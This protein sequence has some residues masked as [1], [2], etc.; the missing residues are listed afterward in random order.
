M[1]FA[2]S[3]MQSQLALAPN[4]LVL[5][6][7]CR[8]VFPPAGTIIPRKPPTARIGETC[9]IIRNYQ[10]LRLAFPLSSFIN[11]RKLP[12][13][14]V[15]LAKFASAVFSF[16]PIPFVA[17]AC[18]KRSWPWLFWRAK[19][20]KLLFLALHPTLQFSENLWRA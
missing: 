8:I 17:W 14:L 4:L 1:W 12:S 15:S 6:S 9:T 16:F 19:M 13:D 3:H 5:Q 20:L 18:I 7:K 10:G 2:Q 11:L